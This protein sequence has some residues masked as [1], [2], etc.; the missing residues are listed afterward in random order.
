MVPVP[1][2][3]KTGIDAWV[4]AAENSAGPVF[5]AV[6]KAG[7]VAAHGFSPK[8]IWGAVKSAC[9]K[10]GLRHRTT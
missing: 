4:T 5:R 2:W 10:W 6:N 8:V 1:S 9:S 3:V 7:R